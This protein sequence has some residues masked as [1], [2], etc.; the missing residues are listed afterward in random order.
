MLYV[1]NGRTLCWGESKWARNGGKELSSSRGAYHAFFFFFCAL[2][3]EILY[4]FSTL[5]SS[6]YLL[7]FFVVAVFVCSVDAKR[8]LELRGSEFSHLPALGTRVE[9]LF[10][11]SGCL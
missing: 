5:L 11:L 9:H 4:S 7:F 10:A 6:Y 2:L 8:L 1:E 3:P